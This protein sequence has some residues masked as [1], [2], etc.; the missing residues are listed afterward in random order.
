MVAMLEHAKKGSF[1]VQLWLPFV[2]VIG[3]TAYPFSQVS[4]PMDTAA[5]N[6]IQ[7]SKLFLIGRHRESLHL[8]EVLEETAPNEPLTLRL[9]AAN[10]NALREKKGA[11]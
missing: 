10:A 11:R 5:I 1:P 4:D 8:I 7:A 2:L 9:K 3:L 6:R